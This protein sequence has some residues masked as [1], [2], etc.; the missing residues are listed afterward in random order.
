MNILSVTK[1]IKNILR[2]IPG[3]QQD[4]SKL[5]D[6]I[7]QLESRLVNVCVFGEFSSGKSSVINALISYPLLPVADRPLTSKVIAVKHSE[8][9]YLICRWSSSLTRDAARIIKKTLTTIE[10]RIATKRKDKNGN[11]I[12]WVD[13]MMGIEYHA[14]DM[15]CIKNFLWIL[16]ASQYD[17]MCI[18]GAKGCKWIS[19]VVTFIK[20]ICR[21]FRNKRESSG[22]KI[23]K[24]PIHAELIDKIE[25]GLP[26][27]TGLNN[28]C[29]LDAPGAGSV[30]T[31]SAITENAAQTSQIIMHVFDAEHIGSKLTEEMLGDA[32]HHDATTTYVLNKRDSLSDS[33]L[34]EVC[35]LL[36]E[37]YA[38]EPIAV[39]ALYENC[40]CMLANGVCKV[41]SVL[42]N[43][44]VNLNLLMSSAAWDRCNMENNRNVLVK[45]LHELSNCESLGKQIASSIDI[46][47]KDRL[48]DFCRKALYNISEF[49]LQK[50]R[51]RLAEMEMPPSRNKLLSEISALQNLCQL[52]E[53]YREDEMR[54]FDSDCAQGI[55]TAL[56]NVQ[57]KFDKALSNSL[58]LSFDQFECGLKASVASALSFHFA[59]EIQS[60]IDGYFAKSR[61][62]RDAFITENKLEITPKAPLAPLDWGSEEHFLSLVQKQTCSILRPILKDTA[63]KPWL[64]FIR[65]GALEAYRKQKRKLCMQEWRIRIVDVFS[66]EEKRITK[67]CKRAARGGVSP[68]QDLRKAKMSE[69]KALEQSV[70]D[71]GKELSNNLEYQ[72]LREIQMNLAEQFN[73][74]EK[75]IKNEH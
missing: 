53:D 28:A 69:Q 27:P 16:Q 18:P 3:S 9:P 26:L 64:S 74:L 70:D 73:N 51:C 47:E 68:L 44:K 39:S 14:P 40:S 33:S 71:L 21:S 10:S 56:N 32:E 43:P 5:D 23:K 6:Y 48:H 63:A 35:S 62:R 29:F 2:E 20:D 57:K 22:K 12:K 37:K 38:I 49:Y 31:Y 7:S 42:N 17:D 1:S 4:C 30:Y 8:N 59:Y 61:L 72:R 11:R 24:L 75:E 34:K 60:V 67:M 13:E 41:A 45:Y 55:S 54:K 50:V 65:P 52:I 15:L 19:A 58:A 36:H 66:E 25:V 46:M